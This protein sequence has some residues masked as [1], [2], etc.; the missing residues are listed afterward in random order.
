MAGEKM[1][2]IIIEI[3]ESFRDCFM[4][5][6]DEDDALECIKKVY[7]PWEVELF[8]ENFEITKYYN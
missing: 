6:K 5:L 8:L 2:K 1:E 7:E 3:E 4:F